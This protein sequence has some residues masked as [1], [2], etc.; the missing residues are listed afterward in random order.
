MR[1]LDERG[2]AGSG[3]VSRVR[4]E[5]REVS[6]PTCGATSPRRS[7]SEIADFVSQRHFHTWRDRSAL[8]GNR[9]KVSAIYISGTEELW[10]TC[11]KP[12]KKHFE[13]KDLRLFTLHTKL[14]FELLNSETMRIG[15]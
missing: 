15:Q 8:W 10:Q 2:N 3:E 13:R 12:L 7:M 9:P 11:R 4:A 6:A 14:G 5:H 1:S